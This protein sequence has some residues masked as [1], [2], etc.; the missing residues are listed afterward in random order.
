MRFL[1]VTALFLSSLLTVTLFAQNKKRQVELKWSDV[2]RGDPSIDPD[3]RFLVGN[4]QFFQD[5]TYMF[6]DS[7]IQREKANTFDAFGHIKIEKGDTLFVY[8][9]E[10]YYDGNTK[11]AK[12]RGN[13][14]MINKSVTLTT[15][16]LDYNLKTDVGYYNKGG[17]I[18][19]QDDTLKS[20][21][22]IYYSQSDII[23]FKENVE[24]T[25]PDYKLFTDTLKYD[26][27]NR[28]ATILGPTNLYSDSSKM[29]AEEGWYNMQQRY[30]QLNRNAKIYSR[31]QILSG[32]TISFDRISGYGKFN[33]YVSMQDTSRSAI[34]R[35]KQGWYNDIT[36]KAMV[37]DSAEFV[38]YSG[39][40]SL[41]LHADTFRTE[42]DTLGNSLIKAYYNVKFYR[43]DI[44]GVCDSLSYSISDSIIKMYHKPYLWSAFNQ[45][46]GEIIEIFSKGSNISHVLLNENAFISSR[47][48]S[49]RFHQIK[50]QK[51]ISYF[52]NSTLSKVYVDGNAQSIYFPQDGP[53]VVGINKVESSYLT[54]WFNRSKVRRIKM[55][56]NVKG[57]LKPEV[58]LPTEK[59]RLEGFEWNMKDRPRSRIDIFKESP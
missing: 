36:D 41:Y 54:I 40:D 4:V 37:T 15:D 11:I 46:K 1:R 18:I 25:T 33:G 19:D 26:S 28:I 53:Y 51:I 17:I 14:K 5:G 38:Q 42:P 45:M 48:D 8:G 29:F 59:D 10:L 27:R 2:M 39:F 21:R 35:G 58:S 47:L 34:V 30:L 20:Q 7:A 55:E 49:L 24:G 32:D 13:V 16:Y 23:Y 43:I 22:G 44:Q 9:N 12:L 31:A 6:S 3:A 57:N 52:D 50:G 56:P